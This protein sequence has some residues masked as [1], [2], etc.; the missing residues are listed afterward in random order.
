MKK[1]KA[2]EVEQTLSYPLPPAQEK[3]FV[4]ATMVSSSQSA[5]PKYAAV[6]RVPVAG[7]DAMSVEL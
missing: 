3:K 2:A 6:P 7:A 5:L 1:P 4:K